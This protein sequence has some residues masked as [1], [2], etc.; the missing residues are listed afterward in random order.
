MELI[1]IELRMEAQTM[2]S[3]SQV[4]LLLRRKQKGQESQ[5]E[6]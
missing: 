6:K 2:V 4:V 3:V 1:I 5:V